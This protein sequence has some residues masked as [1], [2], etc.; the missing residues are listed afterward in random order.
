MIPLDQPS[1]TLG[2]VHFDSSTNKSTWQSVC[3][4]IHCLNGSE[5]P[6]D[7]VLSNGAVKLMRTRIRL[8]AQPKSMRSII[9][10]S[11]REQRHGLA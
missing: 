11:Q 7:Q 9:N 8:L 1:L 4:P 2:Y 10:V 5:R 3:L 6:A